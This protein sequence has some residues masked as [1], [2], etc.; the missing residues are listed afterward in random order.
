MYFS[1]QTFS[2]L[3]ILISISWNAYNTHQY[4]LL[5]ERQMKLETILN[6]LLPSSPSIV[7][8][9]H[10]QTRIEQWFNQIYGFIEKILSKNTKQIKTTTAVPIIERHRRYI[11]E[12]S[13]TNCVCPPGLKG[14]KG[15]RGFAGFPGEMGPKGERGHPGSIVWNGIKGEKGEPGQGDDG[16]SSAQI[17]S[18]QGPSGPPGPQGPPGPKGDMGPSGGFN[19]NIK[20]GPPGQDGLPGEKG[21]R[22]EPGIQGPPGEKGDRGDEGK[23]GFRGRPGPPGPAG[24]DALPCPRELLLNF[25]STC[26]S[27]C[28]KP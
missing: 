1:T 14:E 20:V 3:L 24:M 28:K 16:M 11:Q 9:Q 10:D 7:H 8:I 23:R 21:S 2:I 22:G 25:D 26:N 5:A 19:D 6:E 4:R 27:C 17:R 15:D 18:V 13:M 12:S